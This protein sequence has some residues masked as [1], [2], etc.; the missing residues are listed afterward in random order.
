[1]EGEM[2]VLFDVLDMRAWVALSPARAL[3]QYPAAGQ[4]QAH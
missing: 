1:M 3:M 4:E 2:Q